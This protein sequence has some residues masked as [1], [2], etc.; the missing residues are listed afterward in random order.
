M[1]YL[2]QITTHTAQLRRRSPSAR[3]QRNK[4][5]ICFLGLAADICFGEQPG[6][7]VDETRIDNEAGCVEGCCVLICDGAGDGVFLRGREGEDVLEF[8]EWHFDCFCQLKNFL[9]VYLIRER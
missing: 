2:H 6:T 9:D 1:P 5:P 4:K 8:I 3:V 7:D